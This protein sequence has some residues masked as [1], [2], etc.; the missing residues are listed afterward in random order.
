M[1]ESTT[2]ILKNICKKVK[3]TKIH[4]HQVEFPIRKVKI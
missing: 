1:F 3:N 4:G 2:R